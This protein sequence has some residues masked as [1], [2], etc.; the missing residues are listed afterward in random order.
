M[1]FKIEYEDE[2]IEY[3]FARCYSDAYDVG[4]ELKESP[5]IKVTLLALSNDSDLKK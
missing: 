2:S 5:I 4:A 1:E 3:I